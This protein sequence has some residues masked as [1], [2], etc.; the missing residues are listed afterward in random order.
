M[1]KETSYLL[2]SSTRKELYEDRLWLLIKGHY[3]LLIRALSFI[4]GHFFDRTKGQ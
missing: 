1:R 4:A 3:H 2:G